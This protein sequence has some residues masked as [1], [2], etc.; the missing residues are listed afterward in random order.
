MLQKNDRIVAQEIVHK[1]EEV[2]LKKETGG[3]QG[4]NNL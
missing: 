3:F 4:K 1:Q 2:V